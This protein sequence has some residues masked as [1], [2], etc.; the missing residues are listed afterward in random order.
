ME[1]RNGLQCKR[2]VAG[3]GSKL[4]PPSADETSSGVCFDDEDED[5][6]DKDDEDE[7]DEDDEDEDG[8]EDDDEY[9]DEYYDDIVIIVFGL[10]KP[11]GGLLGPC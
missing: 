8:E 11:L 9:Y 6:E 7:D 2:V 4:K 3:G 5:D 10:L 1:C